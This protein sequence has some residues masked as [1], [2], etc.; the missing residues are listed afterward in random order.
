MLLGKCARDGNSKF[1]GIGHT[2]FPCDFL[3]VQ[4]KCRANVSIWW[5]FGRCCGH[6]VTNASALGLVWAHK[7]LHRNLACFHALPHVNGRQTLMFAQIPA[8]LGAEQLWEWTEAYHLL[9]TKGAIWGVSHSKLQSVHS[10]QET[11]V[12][13]VWTQIWLTAHT[14]IC[15]ADWLGVR[16]M[17]KSCGAWNVGTLLKAMWSD[18]SCAV[19][20]PQATQFL[21][22]V[23]HKCCKWDCSD[24]DLKC[25]QLCG[26]E[27]LLMLTV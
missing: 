5:Q 4:T 16:D 9:Q 20:L 15:C 3:L 13:I 24:F 7:K 19:C 23:G 2:T 14:L 18:N 10:V 27:L 26:H 11:S 22:E 17:C 6:S 21:L 25:W 1:N 8:V 12:P